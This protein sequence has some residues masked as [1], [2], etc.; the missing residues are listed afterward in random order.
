MCHNNINE[1]KIMERLKNIGT[2]EEVYKGLAH[3]TAG[4]LIKNDIITKQYGSKII[5]ISKKL[6]EKMK[7]NF[8]IFR[9][10]NP[11]YLK[12]HKRTACNNNEKKH[13]TSKTQK[14]SFMSDNKIKNIYYPELSGIDINVL[15]SELAK[16]EEEED[17][18][19]HETHLKSKEFIIEEDIPEI[20]IN[21]L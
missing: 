6:S 21:E 12:R 2:R 8:N 5:Y 4:G 20:N 9:S 17:K 10:N 15:K 19:I 16:E 13:I 11:N 18:N 3:K 7:I 14:L 1:K